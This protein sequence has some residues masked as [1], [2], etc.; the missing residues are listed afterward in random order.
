MI[1]EQVDTGEVEVELE[2]LTTDLIRR[3]LEFATSVEQDFIAND[4]DIERI[5]SRLKQITGN[6]QSNFGGLDIILIG[7]LRQLQP[8]RSAPIYKQPKQTI[9]G[10]ILRRNLRFYELNEVMRQAN[11]QF[12]SI[13]T[14]IGN[15]EQLDEIEIT[16]IESRFCIVKESELKYPQDIPLFNTNNSVNEYNNK[17]LNA[18]ADRITSTTKDIYIGCT[19]KEQET[20]VRQKLHKMSLIDTNGLLYQTIY[21][22]NIYYIITTNIDVTDG[23]P[24]GAVGKIIHVETN[25]EGLVETI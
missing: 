11:Q 10:P 24:N 6:F 16:L 18:S 4:P 14:K 20:F 21:V 2:L 23:L 1:I 12:S 15:G 17:I 25:D 22:N 3:G 13:L 5:D 7:D 9:V 8:V 19:S